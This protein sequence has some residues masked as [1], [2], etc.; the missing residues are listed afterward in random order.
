VTLPG[1]GTPLAA[2]V[3]LGG[4]GPSKRW[5]LRTDR[6]TWMVKTCSAPVAWERRQMR[7]AG[8]LEQAAYGAGVAMPRPVVPPGPAIGLWQAVGPEIGPWPPVGTAYLRAAE[9]IDGT[10]PAANTVPLARWLGRTLATIDKLGLPADPTAGVG[11]TLHPLPDWRR[12]L[13]RTHAAGLLDRREVA[14]GFAAVTELTALVTAA[15]ATR[16]TFQLGHRDANAR[17]FLLTDR[18]PVLIDF[19]SAGPEVPWWGVV[20]HAWDLARSDLPVLAPAVL[21]AYA[22]NGGVIGPAD[23]TAFAALARGVLDG[24]AFH[25]RLVNPQ[26]AALRNLRL[27]VRGV[28]EVPRQIDEWVH[29]LP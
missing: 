19:D 25:L 18:G 3:A 8:T 22:E 12:W 20:Y 9:W 15:L 17:N 1:F 27:Y 29:R 23:A 26:A 2:P 24:F 10:P 13:D 16:P 6:G 28:P 11:Y 5:R 14:D 4:G 7:D 21:D